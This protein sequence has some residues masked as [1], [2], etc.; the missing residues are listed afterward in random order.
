[1]FSFFSVTNFGYLNFILFHIVGQLCYLSPLN[2]VFFSL[3]GWYKWWPWIARTDWSFAAILCSG[4]QQ[5]SQSW[6]EIWCR[7]SY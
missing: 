4:V 5:T 2:Q 1:V 7:T 6:C 3:F